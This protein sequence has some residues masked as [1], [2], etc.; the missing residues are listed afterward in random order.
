MAHLFTIRYNRK[1]CT[2]FLFFSF[3]IVGIFAGYHF[4]SQIDIIHFSLMRSALTSRVSIVSLLL[5]HILPFLLVILIDNFLSKAFI[6]IMLFIKAF[7][8]SSI[9]FLISFSFW[10]AGWLVRNLLLFS[11][12][13][14]SFYFLLFSVRIVDC[15]K[16]NLLITSIMIS[17]CCLI[18]HYII[19][20]I[21][22]AIYI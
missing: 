18:N 4:A 5:V 21:L 1:A 19:S 8:F 13:V 3:W 7:L 11:D 9:S 20:S 2:K 14:I 6:S 10:K 15:K 17:I 16:P 12:S 22:S